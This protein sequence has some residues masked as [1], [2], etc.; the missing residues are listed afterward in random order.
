ML[1]RVWLRLHG[2]T[3]SLGKGMDAWRVLLIEVEKKGD[4]ILSTSLR[5]GKYQAVWHDAQLRS[6]RAAKS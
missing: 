1:E 5:S 3:H 2:E 6:A 4:L